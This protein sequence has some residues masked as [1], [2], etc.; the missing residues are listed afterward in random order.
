ML[1]F[2]LMS[3]ST[4]EEKVPDEFYADILIDIGGREYSAAYEK[5]NG[6]D[7]LMFASPENLSGLELVLKNGVTTVKIGETVFESET[8]SGMFDFLPVAGN[9]TK[10]KGNREYTIYNIRGVE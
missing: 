6:F 7:K 3:C 10:T 9:E 4:A 5:R 2:L 8:F 1:A